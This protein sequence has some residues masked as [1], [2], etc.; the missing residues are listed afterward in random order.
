MELEQQEELYPF[1][2]PG[3]KGGPT[4]TSSILISPSLRYSE[5]KGPGDE[6]LGGNEHGD[7]SRPDICVAP[8]RDVR[9]VIPG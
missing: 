7:N 8:K 1:S 5:E 6:E 2:C 3:T 9:E 4:Q